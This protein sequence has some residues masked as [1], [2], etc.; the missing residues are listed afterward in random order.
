MIARTIDKLTAEHPAFAEFCKKRIEYIFDTSAGTNIALCIISA[1]AA[2]IFT[3]GNDLLPKLAAI[4]LAIAVWAVCALHAGFMKQ[5]SFVIFSAV[6]LTLPY[7]FII[8]PQ[9]AGEA[10]ASD[11][12]LMLSDFVQSVIL[13]PVLLISGNEDPQIISV[14]IFAISAAIFLIGMYIRNNAKKSDFYCR[15]RLDQLT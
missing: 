2:G 1:L 7:I 4:I 9:S 5:W 3:G 12:A 8:I 11:I 10:S 6:Y 14:I 15:T 13:R